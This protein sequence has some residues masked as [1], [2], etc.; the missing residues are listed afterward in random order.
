MANNIHLFLHILET[1]LTMHPYNNIKNVNTIK[2][3][4][5]QLK[6]I[7]TIVKLFSAFQGLKGKLGK[8]TIKFQLYLIK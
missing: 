2:N 1:S 4:I 8:I 5:F 3:R 7:N 6:Y